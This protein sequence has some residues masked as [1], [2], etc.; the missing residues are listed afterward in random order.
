MQ[1]KYILHWQHTIHQ[2][3]KLEFSNTFINEYKPSCYLE[4][5][6]N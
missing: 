6:S 3:K 4:I 5:T 1:Y 2:S